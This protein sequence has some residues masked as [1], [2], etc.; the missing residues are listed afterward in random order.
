MSK[1]SKGR[2]TIE[3]EL[4]KQRLNFIL[5][6]D[7]ASYEERKTAVLMMEFV[8]T[9]SG[10]YNGFSYLTKFDLG[11]DV[12]VGVHVDDNGFVLSEEERFVGTDEFRRRYF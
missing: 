10:N 7:T 6:T 4:L 1:V 2:K 8:L 9:E 5:A 3:V 11:Q 12:V